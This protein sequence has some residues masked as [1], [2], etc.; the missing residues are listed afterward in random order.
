MRVRG[1]V[2]CE[3]EFVRHDRSAMLRLIRIAKRQVQRKDDGG[4]P[5]RKPC[6]ARR[7]HG[8]AS[9]LDLGRCR[10]AILAPYVRGRFSIYVI[11]ADG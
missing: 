4:A 9:A 6:D 5:G 8:K 10:L 11:D 3:R 7:C 1:F 2:A